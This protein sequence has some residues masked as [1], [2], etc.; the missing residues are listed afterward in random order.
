MAWDGWDA[1]DSFRYLTPQQY[2]EGFV[3]AKDKDNFLEALQAR[4]VKNTKRHNGIQWSDVV[5]RI[6]AT[7]EKLAALWEMEQTGGE[8]DVIGRDKKTGEFVFVDCSIESPGGRRSLCYDQEALQAR[9][10][11]KPQGSALGVAASMGVELLSE[12]EYREI[13]LLGPVDLKTSSWIRTPADI[14]TLGGALFCDRRYNTV[15][16]YHNGAESYYAARGFRA[17]LRV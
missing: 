3:K 17:S 7:K 1:Q 8:P 15:F 9:K 16:T 10:E 2:G 6:N 13:Q 14:R 12:A 5:V 11:N 4:F